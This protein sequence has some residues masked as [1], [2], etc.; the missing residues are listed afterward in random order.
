GDPLAPC[1]RCMSG[2]I[3]SGLRAYVE[4]HFGATV[5]RAEILAPDAGGQTTAKVVGYGAPVRLWLRAGDGTQR[6]CVLHTVRATAFGQE[7]RSDRAQQQLLAWDTYPLVPR[8]A[9]ALDVGAVNRDG[10]LVSLADAQELYLV[11]EWA[12]GTMYADDLRRLA[13]GGPLRELDVERTRALARYLA[14]LHERLTPDR[15]TWERC[16]RD[17]VGNGEGLF[18]IADAYGPQ[19]AEALLEP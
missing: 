9:A 4:R 2:E 17:T 1:E 16:L 6:Q 8:Q 15:V 12:Q 5:E 11:T 7:R 13:H 18:G 19:H 10:T 14:R 3:P